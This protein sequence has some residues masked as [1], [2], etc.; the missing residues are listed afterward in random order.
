MISNWRLAATLQITVY[1]FYKL[2]GTQATFLVTAKRAMCYCISC[3]DSRSTPL[4]ITWATIQAT[5]LPENWCRYTNKKSCFQCHV[6]S[7][8]AIVFSFRE[9]DLRGSIDCR[10]GALQ[11][12]DG[13]ST[14]LAA[15]QQFCGKQ[16]PKLPQSTGNAV[17]FQLKSNT[18]LRWALFRIDYVAVDNSS[19]RVDAIAETG[20]LMNKKFTHKMRL[21]WS[22]L[23]HVCSFLI[24]D[25]LYQLLVTQYR[26]VVLPQTIATNVNVEYGYPIVKWVVV[27][28]LKDK[29][30]TRIIV[31]V[32]HHIISEHISVTVVSRK[33]KH[34]WS[35][36]AY[37]V[38]TTYLHFSYNAQDNHEISDFSHKYQICYSIW[39]IELAESMKK[40]VRSIS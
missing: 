15:P 29:K 37:Y 6:Y 10:S 14:A 11:Y 8:Q 40:T 26:G 13:N 16:L 39:Y 27:T 12:Y 5:N 25:S 33:S 7:F 23:Y 17:V 31:L 9:F 3:S 21:S 20:K 18:S 30:D 32:T 28:W 2:R 35:C 1:Y 38:I 24:P 22:I 34:T 4:V 36:C 19:E